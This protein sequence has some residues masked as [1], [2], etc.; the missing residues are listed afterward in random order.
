MHTR[1]VSKYGEITIDEHVYRVP[2]VPPRCRVL[3]K[4]YWDRL[5]VADE[6][7]EKLLHTCPRT[8]FQNPKAIDW[9]SELEIFIRKPRAV[10]RAVYLKAM[11][12]SIKD[13]FLSTNDLGERG[14]R[15][16]TMVDVLR[17]YP[18]EVAERAAVTSLKCGRMDGAS[19]KI[20]AA[21]EAGMLY[22]EPTPFQE[23]WTPSEVAQW[24][25]D[26]SVYDILGVVS[27]R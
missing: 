2:G 1:V 6:H 23:P 5:E 4:A 20:F 10:E 9:A 13:Y 3:V 27:L 24:H 8:Y 15:I 12:D 21:H 19:L 22:P 17:Q 26:L 11:P 18:L 16:S 7:G 25:P 14:K